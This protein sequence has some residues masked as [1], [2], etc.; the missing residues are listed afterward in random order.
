MSSAVRIRPP[1]DDEHVACRMLLG[2]GA[3]AT[4]NTR[5]L[6]ALQDEAP[7]IAGA[8]AFVSGTRV[9][10]SVRIHVVPTRRRLGIGTRLM[11]PIV[12]H[13]GALG[14]DGVMGLL[15]SPAEDAARPFLD[16]VG[17]AVA[18]RV[19]TARGDIGAAMDGVLP[20]ADRLQRSAAGRGLSVVPLASAP[21]NA[22]VALYL[23]ELVRNPYTAPWAL[24]DELTTPRY[25]DSPVLMSG[26]RIAG[27]L[28]YHHDTRTHVATIPARIVAP[29]FQGGPTNL[30]MLAA[31]LRA[32]AAAGVRE[33]EFDIPDGNTDTAKLA[34]RLQARIMLEKYSYFKATR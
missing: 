13:A 15:Q 30:L 11:A 1:R 10:H 6:L 20:L 32:G 21:R 5:F 33:I 8:A 27:F 26:D 16:A 4:A 22:V 14:H 17:F 34:R 28:L 19:A 23:T 3:T 29:D 9:T 31:A 24:V 2:R 25:K 12:E 18:G 7:F